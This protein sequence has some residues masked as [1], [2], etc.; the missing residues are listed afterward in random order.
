M[1]WRYHC[2]THVSRTKKQFWDD[3]AICTFMSNDKH[4]DSVHC[5]RQTSQVSQLERQ[6]IEDRN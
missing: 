4:A 5:K 2:S 6:T 1:L 3:D